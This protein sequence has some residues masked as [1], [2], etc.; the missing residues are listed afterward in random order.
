MTAGTIRTAPRPRGPDSGLMRIGTA[1]LAA[2]L[3]ALCACGRG[4]PPPAPSLTPVAER[5]TL[6]YDNAGGVQDSLRMVVRDQD[7][8]RRIWERATSAQPAPPPFPQVDFDRDMLLVVA[9]GRMS[10]DDEIRVDSV[11]VRRDPAAPRDRREVLTAVVRTTEGCRRLNADAYPLEIVRVRR[12]DG[13]V[14]WTERRGRAD[15]CR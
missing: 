15:G 1:L 12:F 3:A 9:A 13:P 11:A 5:A 7:G 4:G 6:Y 2:A 8:L 10:P 14:E